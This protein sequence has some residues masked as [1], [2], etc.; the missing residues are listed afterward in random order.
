MV[1]IPLNRHLI[2]WCILI[3][4]TCGFYTPRLFASPAYWPTNGW[5]FSTPEEQ[6]MD[7][8]PLIEMMEL[9]RNKEYAINSITI[10]R[11]GYLIID[12]Y[13]YPSQ[14]NTKRVIHSVT[15]SFISALVGIALDKGYIQSVYQPIFEFFPEKTIANLDEQKQSITLEHL[16]TMTSGLDT[17]DDWHSDLPRLAKMVASEDWTQYVLNLPM[18]QAPGNRNRHIGLCSGRNLYHAV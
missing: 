2:S 8:E 16:L 17:N 18:T 9:I 4:L 12:A 11:N 6:G 1:P 13:L 5:R 3:C 15:K 7:S 10:I 14:K